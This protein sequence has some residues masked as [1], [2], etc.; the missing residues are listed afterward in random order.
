MTTVLWSIDP[1][2]WQR[3][4]ASVVANRILSQHHAGAVVL[5]HDI[6]GPTVRAMPA[7]VDGLLGRGYNLVQVS[8]LMGRQ[9]LAPDR[10]SAA[11]RGSEPLATCAR[12]A[13]TEALTGD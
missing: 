12:R 9:G 13:V 10:Q 5:S 11:R 1:L 7:V 6:H 4:G 3:P 8:E 2:D